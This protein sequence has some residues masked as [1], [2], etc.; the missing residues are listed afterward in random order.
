MALTPDNWINIIGIA[1][2]IAASAIASAVAFIF[3]LK[4]DAKTR[5]EEIRP[6]V[7]MNYERGWRD[8]AYLEELVLKNYG[9]TPATIADIQI[10]PAIKNVGKKQFYNDPFDGIGDIPLAP[11]QEM[12]TI[13]G[14]SQPQGANHTIKREKR[15]FV[16]QYKNVLFED[17]FKTEYDIDE[18]KLPQLLEM[19]TG[20]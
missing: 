3:K 18:T 12:R 5:D 11:N 6:N 4:S 16:I 19:G 15:H 14:I 17:E 7:F 13:V 10:T 9:K 20:V 1:V 2:P 8:G